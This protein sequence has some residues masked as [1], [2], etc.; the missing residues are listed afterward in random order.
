MEQ[1]QQKDVLLSYPYESMDPFVQMLREAA[2]DP[3]VGSRIQG[4]RVVLSA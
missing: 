3:D 1:V 4:A 2:A